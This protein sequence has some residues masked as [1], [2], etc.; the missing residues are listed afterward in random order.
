VLLETPYPAF[1][2]ALKQA[3]VNA[4]RRGVCVSVF[5][6]SAANTDRVTTYAAWQN[7]KASLIRA[8]VRVHEH[9]GDGRIHAKGLVIDQKVAWVGSYNFDPRGDRLNLELALIATDPDFVQAVE[10]SLRHRNVAAR[11]LTMPE[12]WRLS[13]G[14]NLPQR[15]KIRGL[16]TIAPL[17]RRSL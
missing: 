9:R 15:L 11:P 12:A 1:S 2:Q 16:Q 17:I 13:P 7:Q 14:T 3:L 5:T 6:N 10:D 4:A 8:G